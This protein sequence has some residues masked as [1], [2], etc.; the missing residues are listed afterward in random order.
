VTIDAFLKSTTNM[1]ADL[2]TYRKAP[3]VAAFVDH[4]LQVNAANWFSRHRLLGPASAQIIMGGV[5]V[6]QEGRLEDRGAACAGH[7]DPVGS[8]RPTAGRP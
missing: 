8:P 3:I 7:H 5:V 4:V 6:G 1:E 2:N